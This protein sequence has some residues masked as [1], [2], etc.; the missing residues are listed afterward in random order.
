MRALNITLDNT[1]L[2]APR[3]G[4]LDSLPYE[5]GERP[6]SGA[7]I[8]VMLINSTPYARVYVPEP[9]RAQ[10][11]QGTAATIYID[12]MPSPF[13]GHVRTI[14]NEAAFTPYYSLTERDRSRL[15]Y[16]AEV[17]L[18]NSGTCGIRPCQTMIE[19]AR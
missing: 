13:A 12:G 19:F 4:L 18:D 1:V 14:S 8:A 2:R 3:P 7:V 9:L 11:H 16:L 17:T 6:A 15:S 5:V 10:V